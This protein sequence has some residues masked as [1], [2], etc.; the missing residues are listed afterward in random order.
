MRN[1]EFHGI[2]YSFLLNTCREAIIN[3][4]KLVLTEFCH[5]ILGLQIIMNVA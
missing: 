1:K 4:E 3:Q 5:Y 2:Y